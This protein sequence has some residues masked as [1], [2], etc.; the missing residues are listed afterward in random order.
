MGANVVNETT[1]NT[2]EL[3]VA[4]VS[5]IT[6]TPAGVTQLPPVGLPGSNTTFHYDFLVTNIGNDP[7]KIF[8]PGQVTIAGSAT[9]DSIKVD[10]N[11][12][13]IFE[14]TIPSGGFTTGSIP[15]NAAVKVRV[16]I[17]TTG[18]ITSGSTLSV[19][20]GDTAPNDNSLATQNQPDNVD[21]ANANE[22]RTIDNPD[23]TSGETAGLPIN[24]ERE[25]SSVQSTV[26]SVNSLN[27]QAFATLFKVRSNYTNSNTPNNLSDDKL[28]YDLTLNVAGTAPT[29]VT[30]KSPVDLI[31]TSIKVDNATVQRI[32]V[33]DAIPVGTHLD[34]VITPVP[35]GWTVVYTTDNTSIN[36]NDASWSTIAPGNLNQVTRIGFINSDPIAK[37]TSQSGL[38]FKV[39]TDG[40]AP[41]ATTATISNIAQLF[42]QSAGEST[43]NLVYDESGDQRPSNYNDDGSIGSNLPNNGVANPTLQGVDT[44][45]NNTGT[46][47]GGEVNSLAIAL[48]GILNGPNLFPATVGPTDNNDDFTNQSAI[49]LPN[50]APG[51]TMNP[52][53]VTFLNTVSIPTST[54]LNDIALVPVPPANPSDLPNGTQ[55]TLSYLANTAIYTYNNGSFTRNSLLPLTLPSPGLN[56]PITYTVIVDLPSGTPLSTDIERGFPVPIRAYIDSIGGPLGIGGNGQYDVG[57]VYNDTID[58]VYTGFLKLYKESRL[59]QHTGPAILLGQ[60]VFSTTAKTPAKGNIIEYRLTYSNISTP[61]SGSGTNSTLNIL[62]IVLTEDGVSNG[63]NWALDSN[64]DGVTDTSHVFQQARDPN[65][66]VTY[67][68]L[69]VS[70]TDAVGVNVTKYIDTIVN[71]LQP[72]ESGTFSFQRKMN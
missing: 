25:A 7:T 30:G 33:S 27:P 53:P 2:V 40:I 20:L 13:G 55:V 65:G 4:E 56:V 5:G 18:G 38:S 59:L 44:N 8:I 64:N 23:G 42:G 15:T 70:V 60:D 58:R 22:V 50:L 28:Q 52:N 3:I 17:T 49:V 67:L 32:L 57:E 71:P 46:G 14:T 12:D 61:Q 31:G 21:G 54:L 66:L 29:N 34:S 63:N 9:T 35:T 62:G 39:K 36:A 45:N 47:I 1:S 16:A 43:N 51:S 24:L 11:G 26:F 19:R 10:L 68:D 72:G 69:G 6:V 41:S 48:S 37:G